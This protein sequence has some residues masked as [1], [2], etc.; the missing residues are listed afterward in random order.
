MS[1]GTSAS[2]A[3]AF[4][5]VSWRCWWQSGSVRVRLIG[6]WSYTADA[7]DEDGPWPDPRRLI[8]ESWSSREREL[9]ASYFEQGFEVW[10]FIGMSECRLCGKFNGSAEFTDDVY[11]W[12]EGLA[13]YVREHSVRLPDEVLSHVRRRHDELRSH[14]LNRDLSVKY[15]GRAF[16]PDYA[17][18]RNR[19]HRDGEVETLVVV[20]R[21]WWPTVTGT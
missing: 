8:D 3:P 21:D 15:A 19:R 10:R 13:H 11:L 7:P 18:D 16:W 14:D 2:A 17:A 6:Y 5:N 20:D 9:V 1:R 12:P 4:A